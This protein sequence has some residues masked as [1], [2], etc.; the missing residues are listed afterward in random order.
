[1]EA[2]PIGM[3]L[4]LFTMLAVGQLPAPPLTS[5]SVA[6]LALGLLWW[7]MGV[8][9]LSTRRPTQSGALTLFLHT[10]GWIGTAAGMIG[11]HLVALIRGND[12][13]IVLVESIL[14]TWL[15]RRGLAHAR[16]G[17]EYGE[18]SRSFN[19]SLGVLLVLMFLAMSLSQRQVLLPPLAASLT[20]FFTSGLILLSLARLSRVCKTRLADGSHADP[21]RVWLLALS[22]LSGLIT[23]GAIILETLFSLFSFDAVLTQLSPLWDALGTLLSWL[24]TGLFWLILTPLFALFSWLFGLLLSHPSARIQPP[25]LPSS[26]IH[27]DE[28][29][30]PLSPEVLA[31]GRWVL[32]GLVVCG[33]LL[34]IWASL[35]RRSKSSVEEAGEEV[36]ETLDA[37]AFLQER[38]RS[39]WQR[40][41][42]KKRRTSLLEAL[43]PHSAR[44]H[45][46]KLLQTIATK[47][48]DL[49]RTNTETPIE[50]EQRLSTHAGRTSPLP[51]GET[52]HDIL[53][54]LT[55][56]YMQERY[57][58]FLT[59]E[60]TR[61][62]L[63][64]WIPSLIKH[65]IGGARHPTMKRRKKA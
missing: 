2:Q 15:W 65:L 45:Y 30:H 62:Y 14:I 4:A 29:P 1:M 63:D 27:G 50:Y 33:V 49:A 42:P 11:P 52:M 46:R 38:W 48:P 28:T 3:M 13:P 10:L 21:T 55:R 23:V 36:R 56:A 47:K 20:L 54:E 37:P 60:P 34:I 31:I 39:W 64:A 40:R 5:V 43:D 53:D 26:P 19:I 8:E 16:H 18:L 57:G 41:L 61:S 58:G 25:P 17:F 51:S 44:A 12:L 7:A 24:L 59:D 9:Y 35:R 22:I 6:G 32:L